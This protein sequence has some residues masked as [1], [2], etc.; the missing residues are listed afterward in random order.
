MPSLYPE[1][2]ERTDSF[3][4]SSVIHM[5]IMVRERGRGGERWGGR[6]RGGEGEEKRNKYIN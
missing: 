4:L 3:K 6:D 5:Y 1:V 2:R